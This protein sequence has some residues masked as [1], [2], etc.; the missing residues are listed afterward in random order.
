MKKTN[1]TAGTSA[2]SIVFYVAS[3]IFLAIAAFSVYQAYETVATY[4]QTYT[5]TFSDIIGIY[6]TSCAQ[7]FAYAFIIYGIGNGLSRISLLNHTLADVMDSAVE[8]IET[9][10]EDIEIIDMSASAE[11]E[12]AVDSKLAAESE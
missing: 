12:K 3:V 4:K 6:F 8:E 7:Y 5:M 11:P 2:I 9:E 10:P 1:K